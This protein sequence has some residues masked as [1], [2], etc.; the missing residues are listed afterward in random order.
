MSEQENVQVVQGLY[1]NFNVGDITAVLGVL[2]DDVAWVSPSI[3]RIPFAGARHG[4][5]SVSEYFRIIAEHQE[6][7]SFEVQGIIAQG[8]Q[9]V[10]YGHYVWHV[11][12]T[13]RSW[14]GDF[15][16]TGPSRVARLR[17][18]RSTLILLPP[19]PLSS[20]K[21]PRILVENAPFELRSIMP[22]QKSAMCSHVIGF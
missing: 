18:F 7:Q 1:G 22:R 4:K 10:V 21:F 13:D 11:K 3:S 17:D 19:W 16:T 6:P 20:L 9:V 12:A 2:S 8:D 15:P 14:E 5:D